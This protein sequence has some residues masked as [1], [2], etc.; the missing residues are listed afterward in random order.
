MLRLT[1][2]RISRHVR[3]HSR[4]IIYGSYSTLVEPET[5]DV[6]IVGGGPAGLALASALGMCSC[7]VLL[8][9]LTSDLGASK[10]VQ[11][12][13]KVTL[14]EAGD[15]SKVRDWSLDQGLYS[16]RVSSITNASQA[17]LNGEHLS[18]AP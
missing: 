18:H 1:S 13:L 12:T 10:V 3:L 11:D 9:L 7:R 14:V 6:V 16:N 5:S 8:T 15:L 4:R 2:R 17:F